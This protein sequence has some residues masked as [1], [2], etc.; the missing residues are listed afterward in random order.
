MEAIDFRQRCSLVLL[1]H[2]VH[3]IDKKCTFAYRASADGATGGRRKRELEEEEEEE[4]FFRDLEEDMEGT[5]L[6]R[7]LPEE[8]DR[9]YYYKP[10]VT[11]DQVY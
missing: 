3:Y 8:E 9:T 10:R 7:A 5:H 4:D 2:T 1:A 6:G 11:C